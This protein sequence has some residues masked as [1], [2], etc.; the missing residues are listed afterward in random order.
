MISAEYLERLLKEIPSPHENA[1]KVMRVLKDSESTPSQVEEIL[2]YDP[3]LTADILRLANSAYFGLPQ[4]IGSVR[5]AVVILG[6]KRV[7]DLLM[8]SCMNSVM[9]RPVEGYDMEKGELWR[10]SVAVSVTSELIAKELGIKGAEEVFTASL[11]H[12]IGK[13]LLGMI[14][15]DR[16]TD[17]KVFLEGHLGFDKLEKEYLGMDHAEAG[18][19]VLTK[20][21]LPERTIN[22]VKYHHSPDDSPIPDSMLD[23]L[24]VSDVTCLILGFT[25]GKE[26]LKY[27][28]SSKAIKRLNLTSTI[29]E[30]AS[31]YTL[32]KMNQLMNV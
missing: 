25:A 30:K 8:V 11:L 3:K 24:H 29:L 5:Q 13:L 6:W 7:Y 20:W 19:F 16:I 26:G 23:I 15:K 4:R 32:E 17:T 28:P 22:A 10:H 14:L 18:A 21:G 9:D 27:E 2:R 31:S 12:D 1:V